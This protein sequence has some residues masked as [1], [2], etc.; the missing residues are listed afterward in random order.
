M[1]YKNVGLQEQERQ[2]TS[3]KSVPVISEQKLRHLTCDTLGK[4]I[5]SGNHE[6]RTELRRM[7]QSKTSVATNE[8]SYKIENTASDRKNAPNASSSNSSSHE[9]IVTVVLD[10]I[11]Q[12]PRILPASSLESV[13]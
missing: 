12:L 7:I 1:K 9:L 13:Y 10:R 3:Q 4:M 8:V 5:K 11:I 6:F 2:F